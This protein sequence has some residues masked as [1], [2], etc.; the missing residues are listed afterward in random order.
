V[1]NKLH[2]KFNELEELLSKLFDGIA[3]DEDT[4]RIEELLSGDP[5]ACE[6]YI[7]YSELCAQMEFELGAKTPLDIDEQSISA[8]ISKSTALF[9]EGQ[10]TK[11]I[12]TPS[13][14]PMPL[15]AVA[16]VILVFIGT[17]SLIINKRL[18]ISPQPVEAKN[19]TQLIENITHE[20]VAV[21]M[22]SVGANFV[23]N[24]VQP[25]TTNNILYP[26]EILLESGIVA[27]EFYSGA[28]VILEGPAIFE[29]TSE[30]SAI[31]REGRIRAL[32][33]P[34]ACGF[35]VSTR[36]IEVVD[37][38]TEFGM[39]IEEDGHLTE[40]HCFD[41]LVDVYENNLSQ[42]GE[43]LRS[44]ETGEAIRIQST[45]IQRMSANSMAFISYSELAQS[46]LENSTLRHEDWRSVIEE[47][48]ANEDIL[49]LYTFEDQ[50]PRER[51]LVNQVSFQN[52]FS[53]GAIVGCRWT[54]GRWPSK[55]GLEFKS[56][57][58]RVHF[59][60]NDP[61]QTITLSAWVRLDS[62]PKRTMCLLSSSDNANNSL[63]WHLQASGN[64]V[65]SIKNDNGKANKNFSSPPIVNRN[66]LGKW[67]HFTTVFDSIDKTVTHYLNAK[68]VSKS[69]IT[70]KGYSQILFG[71]AEIGNSSLKNKNG[72]TPIRFF[73]GRIDELSIFGR[74]LE[75]ETIRH[76]Y[77]VGMP[78]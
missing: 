43:V 34:Q 22:E 77:R 50:G 56:P 74:A 40:V 33:P 24:G 32:V 12:L 3:N 37:L 52:H 4:K 19:S 70:K 46:F 63:S 67:Q 14:R 9:Y 64:L 15:L 48:R 42:K 10:N 29:L 41:G 13:W 8:Q 28:R 62:T 7:D 16:A 6:F 47:I 36:Q 68:E 72:K 51:S 69:E 38:G 76:L 21:L 39:N 78:N 44:L 66:M 71:N 26:G 2:N 1:K 45:K 55:G 57:S 5:E 65:L 11:Q 20:G 30:N 27:I 17:L 18:A 73:S 25:S 35:S 53:H 49:A 54:N 60:S 75:P 61:Y 59:Q 23:D 58:D 31:L